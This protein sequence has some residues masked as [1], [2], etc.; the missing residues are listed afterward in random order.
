MS[1]A[2]RPMLD[3]ERS[4]SPRRFEAVRD[5]C[6][7]RLA[8]RR[9]LAGILSAGSIRLDGVCVASMALS[10]LAALAFHPVSTET[11]PGTLVVSEPVSMTD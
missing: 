8:S 5:A 3:A 10:R 2:R 4:T 9:A 11:Q 7:P 1:V 6:R